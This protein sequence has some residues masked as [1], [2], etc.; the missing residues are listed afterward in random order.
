M[1]TI[2]LIQISQAKAFYSYICPLLG[3]EVHSY[4]VLDKAVLHLKALNKINVH[5]EQIVV[6]SYNS[7]KHEID[8]VIY[9]YSEFMEKMHG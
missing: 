4:N 5:I 6:P 2:D 1:Q 7:E 3:I 8:L 9:S